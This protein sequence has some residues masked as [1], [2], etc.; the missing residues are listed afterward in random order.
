[1]TDC[2][3]Y[4]GKGQ[5]DA[6][7]IK[8]LK[9]ELKWLPGK[10]AYCNGT[11][12]VDSKVLEKV[13]A[14]FTYLSTDLSNDERKRVFKND[15]EAKLRAEAF[16]NQTDFFIAQVEYLY[17]QCNLDYRKIA[18]FFL[19]PRQAAEVPFSERAELIDYIKDIVKYKYDN[20]Q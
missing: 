17:Y 8:R 4:L 18:D 16:E 7:D 12:K 10:C 19:L 13:P 11:G 15:P 6:N 20:G 2:P 14:D 5:V 1:M 9:R 3:R